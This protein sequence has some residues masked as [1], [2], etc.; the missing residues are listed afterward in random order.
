MGNELM[1]FDEAADRVHVLN[2]T[3]AAVWE[4]LAEGCPMAE[5]PARIEARFETA[6]RD[7]AATVRSAIAILREKRLLAEDIPAG[8]PAGFPPR[9]SPPGAH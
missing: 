4:A 7:V 5:L 3:A 2:A 9:T 1:V 8:R 6:G